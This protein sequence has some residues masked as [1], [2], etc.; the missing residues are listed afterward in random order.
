MAGLLETIQK[1]WPVIRGAPWSFAAAVIAIGIVIAGFSELI[2]H[3]EIAGKDATIETQKTEIDAY[4]D[5]LNGATPD[6]AK[7]QIDNSKARIAD[8]ETRVAKVEPRGLKDNERIAIKASLEFIGVSASNIVLSHELSCTD[9][10][11]FATDFG[12]V[13]KSAHWGFVPSG[14]M[15]AMMASP[16][17]LAIVT[18][19][20][21]NPLPEAKALADALTAAKIPFDMV[22][23]PGPPC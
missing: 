15:G 14:V 21:A 7:K 11:Q 9:C 10:A 6:E 18:P 13:L 19:D 5:K 4:K 23:N 22:Q 2:H 16:K 17:G 12:D 8:L 20:A 3:A 1:E